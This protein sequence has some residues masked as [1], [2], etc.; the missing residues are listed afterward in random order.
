MAIFKTSE[1]IALLREAGR[2]LAAVL[3]DVVAATRPGVTTGELDTLAEGQ[4]RAGGDTPSFLGYTPLGANRPYPATLCVSVND[5]VVHGIPNETP[6][7]LREGDMVSLDLGLI[8]RGV[9]VDMARTIAVGKVDE[10]GVRLMEATEASLSAGIAAA[11]PGARIG[12]ISAAIA[13]SAQALGFAIV[14]ELGGHGVGRAVHE[15][16]YVPNEGEAGTGPHL[17]LGMTLAIEPMLNEGSR[18]IFL[19][20]DGYTYRTKDHKRSAHFE[21]TVLLAEGGAV[22]V[23]TTG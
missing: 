4:I 13:R 20:D 19:A 11:R 8:H 1:E 12:D 16:P 2:R 22:I 10:A 9:F 3:E 21:H 14:R 15:A 23:T 17:T 6:K 7:I 18:H 5:E